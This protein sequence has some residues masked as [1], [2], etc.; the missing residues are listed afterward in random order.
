MG[1][2]QVA[3]FLVAIFSIGAGFTSVGFDTLY[4]WYQQYPVL[5]KRPSG[6]E[7]V[8]WDLLFDSSAWIDSTSLTRVALE[9][10]EGLE[11]LGHAGNVSSV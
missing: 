7:L 10:G 11:Y 5:E 1:L 4:P 8:L 6:F 2:R 9:K 3:F